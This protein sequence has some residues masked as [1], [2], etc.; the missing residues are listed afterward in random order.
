MQDELHQFERLDVW[1]LVPRPD[2]KNI[3]A[4]KWLWKNKSD[5]ENI[6]IQNKSLDVKTVF[7]NGPLK[8][9]VY[10]SQSDGFV[11]PDFP[12]HVYRLK[13]ALYGLKQALRAWMQ[14]RL[15]EY[16]RGLQ[17]LGEKL[18]SWSSKNQDC[19]EMS[20]AKAEYVSLSACCVQVIWMRI[21]LLDYGYKCN[22]ILMYCNSKSAIA[23]SCN[24]VQHSG[25][26]HI[27]IR[28]SFML[29]RKELTLT[30]DE[31]RTIF[32][33]P[34]ATNNNHER[35]V[36]APKFSE[37][38]PLLLFML[39]RKELT[40]TL[41]EF[42]TIFQLPQATENN[43]ERFVV[44][45]TVRNTVQD[46]F[47]VSN[48]MSH[49]FRLTSFADHAD[50]SSFKYHNLEDDEM[51]K[52]IFSSV[53]NKTGVGMKIPSWM[54]TDEM[55]LMEHYRMYATVFGVDIPTTQSQPI[56]STQ[57]TH[58]L[59]RALESLFSSSDHRLLHTTPMPTTAEADD[60]IL[61]D[62]I[63]LSLVEQKSRDELEANLKCSK[64]EE[65]LIAEEIEKLVEGTEN[66]ENVEVDSSI[67]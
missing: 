58:R 37:M 39:D 66:V 46:I 41:D 5:A 22:R 43:H 52:S 8:E 10:V 54:I 55:K 38:V 64:V 60:I 27:D 62:T 17:F 11:D 13:K 47:K 24:P 63:Q 45:Q 42:R 7:L 50:V 67:P 16:F 51:V 18:M 28:L 29:D 49:W 4:V 32:Q 35:F 61:Q 40:L 6:V 34:Q 9:E 65:Y 23:I 21:Q 2:G 1:E 14:R 31:V 30:L 15:Q 44:H 53:K 20:T 33:L 26:K 36:V 48:N 25:T 57:G 56:E 19:T 12:D 59:T 3:I